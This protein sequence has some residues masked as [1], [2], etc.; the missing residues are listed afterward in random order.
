AA[1]ANVAGLLL[2]QISARRRELA[3]RMGLGASVG[4]FARDLVGEA[5]LLPALASAAAFVAARAALPLLLAIV[6]SDLPR[7]EQAVIGARA[8]VYTVGVGAFV[9][10]VCTLVPLLT[11]RTSPLEQALRDGG[12]SATGGR[13]NR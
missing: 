5:A 7:V 6:P 11:L 2:V 3:V 13:Q 1:A 9:T 12:R 8:L 10:G 4:A